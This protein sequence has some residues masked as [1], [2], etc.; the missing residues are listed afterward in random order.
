MLWAGLASRLLRLQ[1][2]HSSLMETLKTLQTAGNKVSDLVQKLIPAMQLS[3]DAKSII[4]WLCAAERPLTF[5]EIKLL[6][7][8]SPEKG[9]MM[10]RARQ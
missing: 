5:A 9:I 4:S 10:D 1:T 7:Q 8:A 3:S 2:T 6:M